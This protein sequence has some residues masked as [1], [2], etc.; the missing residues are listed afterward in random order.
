MQ[1]KHE[2]PK[3]LRFKA[4]SIYD[5]R[6]HKEFTE[7]LQEE[8]GAISSLRANFNSK[9]L[10]I[11]YSGEPKVREQI[12]AK[13][14]STPPNC[15]ARFIEKDEATYYLNQAILAGGTL[16]LS[17][18]LPNW[19]K[20]LSTG[21]LVAEPILEGALALVE[22]RKINTEVLDAMALGVSLVR[23]DYMTAVAT[24]MLTCI[25]EYLEATTTQTSNDMLQRLLVSSPGTAWI[26]QANG[27]TI[28]IPASKVK[29]EDIV[30]VSAGNMIP[31]D[32]QII[33]GSATINQ[34]SITGESVPVDK[35]IGAEVL[36]GSLVE[37]GSI[38]IRAVRVGNSTTT[39]RI[40]KF[41]T[42]ALKEKP[43]IQTSAEKLADRRVY[44]TLGMG[45]LTFLVTGNLGRVASV[46]LIDYSCALKLGAPVAIKS[47]LYKAAQKGI[48]I[49]GGVGIETL[50]EVDTVVFDKTGTLTHGKLEVSDIIPLGKVKDKEYLLALIA[51]LEEHTTH[52]VADA[53]VAEAKQE[54]LAHINHDHVEFI[55]A[56][57]LVSHIEGKRVVIGSRHF[58]RDHES[59]DFKIFEKDSKRLDEEGK[60]I[61]YAAKDGEAIGLIGMRDHLRSEAK[62]T[63]EKLYS[64]GVKDVVLLTGDTSLKANALAQELG[65][66]KVYAECE[67][68]DK[69]NIVQS[70]QSEGRKVAFVG[71]G[72][73]DAPALVAADIGIAM[74]R[75]ADLARATADIVLLNDSVA[76][77]GLARDIS[78]DTIKLIKSNFN[79]AIGLNT[80]LYFVA[81]SGTIS[82]VLSSVLH[83]SITI[84]TL[85]RG[86]SAAK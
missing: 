63:V 55:V 64:A 28:E 3:R 37:D 8:V 44:L 45:V 46:L 6:L 70:L 36:S 75:G 53:I 49:K 79:W 73:N 51:S 41:I 48:L 35:E 52:P 76:G 57:G 33:E 50:S 15:R 22:K 67:P 20:I 43:S 30:F 12:I 38:Y 59:V 69:A 23:R 14:K 62:E 72:V 29:E 27:E 9:S 77:V 21:I 10:I 32:G 74:P 18:L 7:S 86:L 39:A 34:A 47:A 83:N 68:E 56:H 84:S 31:I 13:I 54:N 25:G 2:L 42:Q 58:L 17:S 71:D 11:E 24:R 1:I 26:R 80:G 66:T 81:M 40:T 60:L 85:V 16:A 5:S 19:L 78:K 65:I 4:K 61:L 82:P